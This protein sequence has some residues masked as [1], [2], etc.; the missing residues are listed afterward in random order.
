[1]TD[2]QKREA[3]HWIKLVITRGDIEPAE[4]PGFPEWVEANKSWVL[5]GG[6]EIDELLQQLCDE[7]RQELGQ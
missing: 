4:I 2:D 1:M 6:S 7:V 5:Y 3:K